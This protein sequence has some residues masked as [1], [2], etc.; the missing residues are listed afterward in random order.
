MLDLNET[1]G[2]WRKRHPLPPGDSPS[3]AYREHEAAFYREHARIAA[4]NGKE[5]DRKHYRNYAYEQ[6]YAAWQ[7]RQREQK[8]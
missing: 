7:A 6:A 4:A 5:R 8:Q 2:Q 1:L 3:S